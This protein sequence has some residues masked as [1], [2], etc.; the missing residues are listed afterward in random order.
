MMDQTAFLLLDFREV[1]KGKI[2]DSV[3]EG[4]RKSPEGQF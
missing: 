3:E 2:E 4:L 1:A